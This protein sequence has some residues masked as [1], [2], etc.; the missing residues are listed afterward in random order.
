M[1]RRSSGFNARADETREM[2]HLAASRLWWVV[3]GVRVQ[4]A[5][6][7]RTPGPYYEAAAKAIE[8]HKLNAAPIT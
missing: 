7:Y 3:P 5:W 4:L 1:I 8:A 2:I 6:T